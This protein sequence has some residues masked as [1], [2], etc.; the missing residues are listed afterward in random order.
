M[1]VLLPAAGL[2]LLIAANLLNAVRIER[3]FASPWEWA[4]NAVGTIEQHTPPDALIGIFDA[5]YIAY[6]TDRTVT[7]IDGLI[8]GVEFFHYQRERRILDW[9]IENDVQF[10]FDSSKDMAS[11]ERT[12]SRYDSL[13][14]WREVIVLEAEGPAGLLVRLR[15]ATE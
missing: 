9:L 12:L 10:I 8:N 4:H 7:N 14:R 13:D 5:G 15:P 2:L 1:R 11:L 3:V 6:L